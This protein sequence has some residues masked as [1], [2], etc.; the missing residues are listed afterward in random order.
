MHSHKVVITGIGPVSAIGVGREAFTRG[1]H[2]A[3]SGIREITAFDASRYG[4]G[5]AAEIQDFDVDEYLESQKSYLDRASQLGFAAM[6]LAIE[7]ADLD[8]KTLDHDATGLV[9]GTAFGCLET[10]GLFCADLLKKGPHF[11]KP[12]LFPHTY[13]NTTISLLAMEYGLSGPHMCFASGAAAGAQAILCAY[14]WIR[15]GKA[16]VCF[17]GASESLNEFLFAG[18]DRSGRLVRREAGRPPAPF[19]RGR[20]GFAL[21]E[22]GAVLVLESAEHAAARGAPVYGEIRGAGAAGENAVD[23]DSPAAESRIRRAMEL[24]LAEAGL[25]AGGLDHVSANAN[26]SISLDR[27]EVV[28][29][30]RLLDGAPGHALIASIKSLVGETLGAS[31]PLQMAAA[32]VALQSGV[33]PATANL[34]K[35]MDD[36]GVRLRFVIG[37]NAQ[38]NPQTVLMNT[39]DPG[40]SIVSFVLGRGSDPK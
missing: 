4:S 7:D 22:G 3:V 10:L 13:A 17:A 9:F 31:G 24:A 27:N 35:P 18:Y 5:L 33:V 2:S 21:G 30:N 20:S 16:N 8:L 15:M 29:V 40:G 14:D 6:S 28:A 26:G 34:T 11:V 39:I 37:E 36:V 25:E 19:D 38:A 32:I 12:V 23:K 1:L